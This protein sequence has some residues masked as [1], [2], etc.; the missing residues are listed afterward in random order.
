MAEHYQ[1]LKH[2][3][4]GKLNEYV[5]ACVQS[6]ATVLGGAFTDADG[7]F[8]QSMT[9][10][11]NGSVW[12]EHTYEERIYSADGYTVGSKEFKFFLPAWKVNEL[13]KK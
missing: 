9:F 2:H 10:D 3:N 12:K 4:L 7:Y 11:D 5:D 1:T 6:G 13:K 8:Y